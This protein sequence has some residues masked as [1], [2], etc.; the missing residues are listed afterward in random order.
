MGSVAILG[1]G[2]GGLTIARLLD[3]A[4]WRVSVHERMASCSGNGTG[5][6]LLENGVTS[7]RRLGLEGMLDIG[8][9]L[10]QCELLDISGET[11]SRAGVLA[12][13]FYHP[14]FVRELLG[15]L[16]PGLV[17]WGEPVTRLELE[18]RRVKAARLAS[19][20]LIEADLFIACDGNRSACRTSIWPGTQ[21]GPD[22]V[23]EMVCYLEAPDIVSALG[24]RFIKYHDT[25]RPLSVGLAPCSE[26]SLV[27]FI[28]ASRD[29]LH[30]RS[31]DHLVRQSIARTLVSGWSELVDALVERS[32]FSRSYHWR[33]ADLDPLP[34]LVLDNLALLGD[35]AHPMLTFTSQGVASALKDALVLGELLDSP[36]D[37]SSKVAEALETYSRLRLPEVSEIQRH[38][39]HLRENFLNRS[40]T[41]QRIEVPLTLLPSA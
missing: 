37:S 25:T 14:H 12:H 22:L 16:P 2:I 11:I 33:T 13:G 26:T 5:F 21:L 40:L 8:R 6:L 9:P 41:G 4:G 34:T 1:G 29:I 19:G 27:W 38:G 32:D 28:Q 23:H 10:S 20:R 31:T 36:T 3:A 35:A 39:R 24:Q 18:G 17:E 15:Q 30:P 7:L